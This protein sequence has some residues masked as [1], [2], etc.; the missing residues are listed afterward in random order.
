MT[1]SNLR[2]NVLRSFVIMATNL[3]FCFFIQFLIDTNIMGGWGGN[4]IEA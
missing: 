3:P 4:M 1:W 2:F